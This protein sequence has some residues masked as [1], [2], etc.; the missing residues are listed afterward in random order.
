LGADVLHG[1]PHGL[2]L[3]VVEPTV[4]P[5]WAAICAMPRPMAPAPTTPTVV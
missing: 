2:G 1:A 3:G 4:L 5:A